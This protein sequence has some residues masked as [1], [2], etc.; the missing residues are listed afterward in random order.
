MDQSIV[1]LPPLDFQALFESAPGLFLVLDRDL[2]IV[3]VS[4]AYARATKTRRQDILGKN[5]FEVFP[6]NPDDPAAEGVRNLHASLRRVLQTCAA[7]AMPV[8]KY[9]IR[10]PDE[11]G[12]GFEER[13]WSPLNSPVRMPDGTVRYIIHRVEDVTEFMRLKKQGAEQSRLN[14]AMREQALQMETEVFARSREVAAASAR[15]KAANEELARLYEKTRELDEIK[16]RFF[17]NVSHE[18]RTPL[19]LILGP[20]AKQLAAAMPGSE[21]RRDLEVVDRNARLLYR[22]VS[23]LLDVAKLEAGRMEVHYA[24]I[25]LAHLVRLTASNFESLATEKRIRFQVRAAPELPAEVDAEKCQRILL[26]LLANAFKFTPDGGAITISLVGRDGEAAIAVQDNGPGVPAATRETVFERFRQGEEG[27]QRRHGGTGLGLAIVREFALLQGGAARLDDAPGGG[28]IFTVT[29]PLR[30]PAGAQ[31]QEQSS[32]VDEVLGREAVDELRAR[33]RRQARVRA[34][35]DAP[36]VLVVE[37]N[38][39]MNAYVADLLGQDY[40]VVTAFDGEEGLNRALALRPDLILSDV[41]MPRMSGEEMVK[42]LRDHPET[43]ETPI[44]MLTAKADD[45]LRVALLREGVQDY[46]SKPFTDE[47]LLAR[48]ARLVAERRAV[49]ERVREL[50]QRFRVTF[51][52]A[53]VGMAQV[54]PDGRWLR[55]NQALCDI[56]GYSREELLDTTFQQIT[57]PEYLERDLELRAKVISGEI[58]TFTV[59]KR[60]IRKDG[61]PVWV[62]VTVSLIR[63]KDGRPE[64]FVAVIENI[65]RR[66]QAER[67]LA[68]SEASLREAQRLAGIGAWHWDVR[69]GVH[70]WSEEIYRIYGRD[71]AL[72]PAVYPEIK[73]YFTKESWGRLAAAVEKGLGE[74]SRYECDAEV[75]RPDGGRRWIVARGEATRDALGAVVALKGTV[76]DITERKHNE[77]ELRKLSMAVTQ[78]PSSIVIT[79]T[80]GRIEYVNPAFCAIS[81]YSAEEVIGRNPRIL[82]S[83]RTPR[84]SFESLWASL[85]RRAVWDGE[86]INRRKDGSEYVERAIISPVRQADGQV[87]HYLAVKEDITERIRAER[88][89]LAS[90]ERLRLAQE[91]AGIGSFDMDPDSGA[92]ECDARL[93]ALWGFGPDERV[94]QEMLVAGVHPDDRALRDAAYAVAVDPKGE[95]KYRVEYRV[96]GQG[97]QPERTIAASGRAFFQDGHAVRIIGLV[98]DITQRRRLE[99]EVQE[100]RGE[101]EALVSQQVAA[102]TAAA[103]A[104]ELG[105]PMGAI[106]AYAEVALRVLEGG[107]T[108]PDRLRRALEGCITQAQRAGRTLHELLDF[109][110][111]GDVETAPLD[112]NEVIREAIAVTRESGHTDL[113]AELDLQPDLPPVSGNR[114]QVQKVLVNLFHNGIEAMREAGVAPAAIA[115]LVRTV[116]GQDL[117]RVTVRDSGPGLDADAAKRIFEPFFTTKPKGI[118]LGLAISRALIEAHGGQLWVDPDERPGA[119]FHF[120]LPF[121]GP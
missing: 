73:Q 33:S 85:R 120:T 43:A 118:G 27:A 17:A 15:L 45:V 113:Q 13:F 49:G 81:G 65:Q 1:G 121:A 57:P 89:L 21:A 94:T 12:G 87:D 44:V 41:M 7:D 95:G 18:L 78:S 16:T 75:V 86:F 61:Q 104:H 66:K 2:A 69:T 111:K 80:N 48:V 96:L 58:P 119:T 20:V 24:R 36:L 38:P 34:A 91:A 3:A 90:E 64:Y 63:D 99:R 100:R 22:H 106:S 39:D 42:A 76:Q 82:Q 8:Q 110:H 30:A 114:I 105:Q 32:R 26:N 59:E 77:A 112:I 88:R 68:S 74:G 70:R 101:M 35:P 54:A 11:E 108:H 4:D 10:K 115:I 79:D 67:A 25:D 102:Q 56:V 84:T 72:P 51:E 50:E 47:E 109:L 117:V 6:D 62:S 23:D 31:V 83:G 55:V 5:I 52:Q 46:I 53:A 103:I 28:A 93:R 71:P 14:E 60:Y 92:V 97:G 98:Q 19:A 107:T 40:Q 29:L 37:D 9:D 116:S